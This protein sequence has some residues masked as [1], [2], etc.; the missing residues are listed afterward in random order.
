VGTIIVAA[1]AVVYVDANAL[2][3]AVEG[4]Q[5]Y[6]N[7]LRPVW[8]AAR[9]KAARLIGSE[10]LIIETLTG[11]LKRGDRA[12]AAAYEQVLA[13][14]DLQLLPVT[15][16]ILRHGATLRA[17]HGL[18]TPDAI[19]AATALNAG[20]SMYLANDQGFRRIPHISPTILS[21]LLIP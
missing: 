6:A 9:A 19:H 14:G 21:D 3:Y 10:L 2:I 11:P 5:P 4:V 13:A 16:A 20:C 1:S 8:E 18:K 17:N 7:L 15:A 12:L